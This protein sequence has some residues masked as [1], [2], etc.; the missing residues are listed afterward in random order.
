MND[1]KSFFGH[2]GTILLIIAGVLGICYGC[3]YSMQAYRELPDVYQF[4]VGVSVFIVC[5]YVWMLPEI[6][7]IFKSND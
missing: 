1:T 5:T 2:A 3:F 4:P 7:K 6:N